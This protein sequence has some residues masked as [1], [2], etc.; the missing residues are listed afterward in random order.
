METTPVEFEP[1]PSLATPAW[2]EAQDWERAWHGSCANTYNEE[3]KQLQYAARMGLH[4]AATDKACPV[5]HMGGRSV[6][7]IGGGPCS[8][9][10]KCLDVKGTVLDPCAFPPWVGMRYEAAEVRLIRGMAEDFQTEELWDEV[11]LYNCLQHSADPAKIVAN[12]RRWGRVLR[13]Y[14]WIDTGTGAG[15]LHSFAAEQYDALFGARG[16]VETTATGSRAWYGMFAGR[17]AA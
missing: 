9:L 13:V 17:G 15:H 2:R 8:L 10:L 6:L 1:E 7:D 3:T 4:A 16:M 12:A 11:W 14:E 5:Y